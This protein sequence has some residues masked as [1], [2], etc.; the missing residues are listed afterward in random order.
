MDGLRTKL[1]PKKNLLGNWDH[2]VGAD[3]EDTNK[4]CRKYFASFY[5][6]SKFLH[7][8]NFKLPKLEFPDFL[9]ML[10]G[11]FDLPNLNLNWQLPE[12]EFNHKIITKESV[13]QK[14]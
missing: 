3:Y 14:Q 5:D 12:I 4:I 13:E 2:A 10:F 7:S 6:S 1:K 9:K 8:E 11:S